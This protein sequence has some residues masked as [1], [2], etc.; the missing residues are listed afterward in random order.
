M[1]RLNTS[2]KKIKSFKLP[3]IP[4]CYFIELEEA[5]DAIREMIRELEA[6]PISIK[7]VDSL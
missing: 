5:T 6:Q 4:K 2:K 7:T 1:Q 3:V